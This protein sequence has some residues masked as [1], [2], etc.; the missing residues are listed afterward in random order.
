MS[1][2]QK[3]RD[4]L[5]ELDYPIIL[6]NEEDGLL[7]ISK[8]DEGISQMVIGCAAPLLIFEQYIFEI[9]HES[10]EVY[11]QLLQWNREIIHGALVLDEAGRQVIFRDTLQLENLDQ[12]EIEGS[13]HS[14]SLWLSEHS[15]DIINF[16]KK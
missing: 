14:L 2:F 7:I 16:S 13:I 3:V 1:P 11:K 5:L 15:Q 10:V 6:E 9:Q 12:N 4:Y 8:E